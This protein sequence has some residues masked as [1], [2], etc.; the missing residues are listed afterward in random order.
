MDE[1]LKVYDSLCTSMGRGIHIY[2]IFGG[3]SPGQS[4]TP[5][6]AALT[7]DEI[8]ML[9]KYNAISKLTSEEISVL[10]LDCETVYLPRSN[11]RLS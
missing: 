7:H 4:M 2:P 1:V 8:E 9:R 10:C 5:T 6:Y 11:E 3:V